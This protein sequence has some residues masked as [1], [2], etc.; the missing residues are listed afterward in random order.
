M[1]EIRFRAI[2]VNGNVRYGSVV[3]DKNKPVAIIQQMDNP[4]NNGSASGWCFAVK[5]ETVGQFTGL[6]DKHGKE[7]YNGHILYNHDNF[8]CITG[9]GGGEYDDN[10]DKKIVVWDDN[11][12]KFKLDFVNPLYR[13]RGVSGYSLCKANCEKMFEV[14][15]NIYEH[16]H[17]LE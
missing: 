17:L 14:V 12:A 1:R 10:P 15:G 7:I 13:G 6:K 5:P 16:E 2:D 9:W 3:S 11:D 8:G 4:I